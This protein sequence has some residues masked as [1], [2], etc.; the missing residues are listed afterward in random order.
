M[1]Y[2]ELCN[3]AES[4]NGLG[5]F[6]AYHTPETVQYAIDQGLEL[7]DDCLLRGYLY[8]TANVRVLLENGANTKIKSDH[9]R[10]RG[11]G[12]ISTGKEYTLKEYFKACSRDDLA[13][14]LDEYD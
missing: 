4:E 2:E 9:L 3:S 14:L 5:A 8:S 11:G 7:P 1:T 6:C 12:T 13:K 10:V